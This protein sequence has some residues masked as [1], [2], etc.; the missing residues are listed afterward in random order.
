MRISDD[1]MIVALKRA[2][3]VLVPEENIQE[4]TMTVLDSIAQE[5]KSPVTVPLLTV[6]GRVLLDLIA[7]PESSIQSCADRLGM[8][9]ANVAHAMTRLAAEGWGVRSRVDGKNRYTFNYNFLTEHRD[10]IL[11]FAALTE[12]SNRLSAQ[13]GDITLTEGQ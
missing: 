13:S 8:T 1:D 12:V 4:A 7:H 2:L 10:I 6:S 3:S 9:S 5:Q 11:I